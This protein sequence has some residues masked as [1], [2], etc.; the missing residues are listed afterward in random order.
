MLQSGKQ[1]E[2]RML[3]DEEAFYWDTIT[4]AIINA[5]QY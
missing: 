5:R 1:P 3:V 4:D 2:K